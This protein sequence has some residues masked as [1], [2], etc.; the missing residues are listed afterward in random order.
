[1]WGSRRRQTE[2]GWVA[3]VSECLLCLEAPA[4]FPGGLAALWKHMK[5]K[6][7]QKR[8]KEQRVDQSQR[9]KQTQSFRL[10]SIDDDDDDEEE[11]LSVCLSVTA[12]SYWLTIG[13]RSLSAGRCFASPRPA[14][15]Q[16]D[17][18]HCSVRRYCS[19]NTGFKPRLFLL[20]REPIGSHQLK[21][22]RFRL[23]YVWSSGV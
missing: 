19:L 20:S 10:W 4:V 2:V 1:M 16:T 5:T 8:R 18:S 12:R 7:C 17:Q 13:G 11:P 22:G 9:S 14:G 6:K 23:I 3:A 21:P 15:H